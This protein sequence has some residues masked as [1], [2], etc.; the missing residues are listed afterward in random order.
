MPYLIFLITRA[1]P[2][3]NHGFNI[4]YILPIYYIIMMVYII[5]FKNGIQLKRYLKY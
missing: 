3:E 5:F 4:L 2:S 1:A